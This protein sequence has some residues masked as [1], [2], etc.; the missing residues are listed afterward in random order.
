MALLQSDFYFE[1]LKKKIMEDKGFHAQHYGDKHLKRRF[2]VRM[3]NIGVNTHREYMKY[4]DRDPNEY[5]K[6]MDTLT[7]NVTEWF[8]NPDVFDTLKT[9][10]MPELI[11]RR[12]AKGL[13]SIRIWSIGCSD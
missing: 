5:Q 3:R 12:A 1:E 8:R 9:R 10:V 6:L 2:N 4:L 7:V 11:N 13:K